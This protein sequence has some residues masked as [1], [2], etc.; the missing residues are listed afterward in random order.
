[1]PSSAAIVLQGKQRQWSCL[2]ACRDGARLSLH[3]CSLCKQMQRAASTAFFGNSLHSSHPHQ[4]LLSCFWLACCMLCQYSRPRRCCVVAAG[5]TVPA[6]PAI[7]MTAAAGAGVATLI[8]TNPLWVIKTRLQTQHMAIGFSKASMRPYTG[9]FNALA[10]ITREEGLRGLY[11]GLAPSMAG[12]CHVAIQF[13]LY[14]AS[15]VGA[16]T[17]EAMPLQ[18][19]D[20]HPHSSS[21]QSN[22]PKQPA[23]RAQIAPQ[24]EH[25]YIARGS[26]SS[27]YRSSHSINDIDPCSGNGG[28]CKMDAGERF[29][30]DVNSVGRHAAPKCLL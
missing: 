3:I 30:M 28:G 29:K 14:E 19:G 27:S 22:S 13:P 9:T 5:R 16:A 11:S 15:K 2:V 1:M 24:P 18:E 17:R 21:Y 6:T 23:P 7:H 26:S 20:H 8:V 12:I 10:R 25:S 4:D